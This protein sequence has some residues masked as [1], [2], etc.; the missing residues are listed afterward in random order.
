VKMRKIIRMPF[1]SK[2][3]EI[4]QNVRYNID[5]SGTLKRSSL[6]VTSTN[7]QLYTG[8]FSMDFDMSSNFRWSLG[9]GLSYAD[10]TKRR[11]NNYMAFHIS[12]KLE[13]I[14]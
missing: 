9:G 13:I 6:N 1:S 12:T 11:E 7:Y 14:F 3:M 4:D 8:N 10:Y 5:F 2:K